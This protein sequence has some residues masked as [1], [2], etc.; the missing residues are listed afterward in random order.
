MSDYLDNH[1]VKR[2]DYIMGVNFQ[3]IFFEDRTNKSGIGNGIVVVR[4]EDL[5]KD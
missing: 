1:P 3:V 4:I 2:M 5:I